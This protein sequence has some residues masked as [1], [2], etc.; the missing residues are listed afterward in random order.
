MASGNSRPPFRRPCLLLVDDTPAYIEILVELLKPDF[1]LRVA[2]DGTTALEICASNQVIDLILLDVMM[3]GIDGFEVCRRL[4][5]GGSRRDVPI[6]FLTGSTKTAD[7]VQAFKM[8]AVDYVAKP[9]NMHEL[10]ARVNTH[11]ALDRLHRDNERLLLNVL[12]ATIADRLKSG[13][14]RIADFFPNVSVM[15]ADIVGFT[16][17]S[18][19]LPP[20]PL[21]EMLNDLFTQFD[22]LARRHAVE[23][24]KTIGD[25]YMAVCGMPESRADHAVQMA[26]MALDMLA[27]LR[28]FNA[29]R[30]G[31]LHIRI[32]LNAGPVVAGVIGSS[33]FIYDLWGD[34]VN[35]ASRME[36]AGLPDR[37]H[38]TEAFR[39]ALLAQFDFE[40]RG[41]IEV[42]GKGR[43]RT[44]FLVGPK[45][46]V[47][48]HTAQVPL[49][50]A[51][52]AG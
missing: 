37:I 50:R 18:G 8:G 6:I 30:S 47:A 3:P 48:A 27:C 28:D 52:A 16:T 2:T 13:E 25:C 5:T 15:F 36:S 22:A 51:P 24:I 14:E 21:V 12:P 10:L 46:P 34:T 9:V 23:K 31:D 1:E 4:K 49:S 7:I 41:E 17:L 29:T 44:W 11:I 19:G 39:E 38:V 33:K 35:T 40:E 32:G 43:L 26:G 45:S 20:E 42:K